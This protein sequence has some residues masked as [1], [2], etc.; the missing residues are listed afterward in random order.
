MRLKR[1]TFLISS[2]IK[3]YRALFYMFLVYMTILNYVVLFYIETYLLILRQPFQSF[4][5][6]LTEFKMS[7]ISFHKCMESFNVKDDENFP[8]VN[9]GCLVMYSISKVLCSLEM[10]AALFFLSKLSIYNTEITIKMLKIIETFFF[11]FINLI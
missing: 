2:N 8:F 11:S 5:A 6:P 7:R 4:F 9:F 3:F 10:F 1:K